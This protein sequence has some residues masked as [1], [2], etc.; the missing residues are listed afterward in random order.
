MSKIIV[1]SKT[2]KGSNK[3]RN[4]D[5]ITW[6]LP[7]NKE[8]F[9]KKGALFAIID[10]FGGRESAEVSSEFI[11]KTI[12]ET[13]YSLKE[14][15]TTKDRLKKTLIS[16]NEIFYKNWKE[17]KDKRGV[18]ASISLLAL[19]LHSVII[20]NIGD[21][22]IFL[23]RNRTLKQITNDHTWIAE[24]DDIK[25]TDMTFKNILTRS[26]GSKPKIQ[27]D[28]YTVNLKPDDIFL[29]TTDGIT[30]NLNIT[31]IRESTLYKSV[32]EVPVY[33]ANSAIRSGCN[34]NCSVFLIKIS[35]IPVK[36]K[37]IPSS[38]KEIIEE[39]IHAYTKSEESLTEKNEFQLK[40]S[41]KQDDEKPQRI[42]ILDTEFDE[43]IKKRFSVRNVIILSILLFLIMFI[44][45]IINPFKSNDKNNTS[46]NI[47]TDSN[48]INTSNN[49]DSIK[50]IQ[51][52]SETSIVFYFVNTAKIQGLATTTW[53]FLYPI[54]LAEID[55]SK[56]FVSSFLTNG[57]TYDSFQS[58]IY[59]FQPYEIS[60][61]IQLFFN[62]LPPKDITMVKRPLNI[63][64]EVGN[65]LEN[66][67]N[68]IPDT[69]RIDDNNIDTVFLLVNS[70]YPGDT[71]SL[72]LA[73]SLQANTINQIPIHVAAIM[74]PVDSTERVQTRIKCSEKDIILSRSL[75]YSLGLNAEIYTR[76][77]SIPKIFFII[78]NNFQRYLENQ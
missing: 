16:V 5:L 31:E 49:D 21:S 45:F 3:S 4:E 23:V 48:F 72:R 42:D 77:D 68:Y 27:P 65:D 51:P 53:K 13:Y 56:I 71:L 32:E 52:L 50:V 57:L 75:S 12:F 36:Y 20:A 19:K 58:Y 14:N 62:K 55:T 54:L 10:G 38:R 61:T 22:R 67:G 64:L 39:N 60:E 43:N 17:N 63:I 15:I 46:L 34:D 8:E 74:H 33:L 2:I 78:N 29:M 69:I 35:E 11:A 73:N 24:H 76:I 28:I 6:K 7:E 40:S 66:S 37:E 70:R 18:G 25:L 47:S 59:I 9:L 30:D 1:S 41:N 26:L 44:F